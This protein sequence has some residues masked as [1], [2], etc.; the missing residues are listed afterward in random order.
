[1]AKF[2]GV[3][4]ASRKLDEPIPFELSGP[5]LLKAADKA[6]KDL[7]NTRSKSDPVKHPSH[8]TAHPSGVECLTITRHMNFSLGNAVKYIWRAG[9]KSQDP[10]QD[11]EKAVFY[12][13]DEI[14]RLRGG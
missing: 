4:P 14:R 12:L 5:E 11:L 2:K 1:M 10:C 13:Q 7:E 6:V 9:L 3:L 8:Y